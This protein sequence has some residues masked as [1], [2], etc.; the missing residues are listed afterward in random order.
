[1]SNSEPTEWLPAWIRRQLE[2]GAVPRATVPVADTEAVYLYG[3]IGVDVALASTGDV[4]VSEYE[5]DSVE[6]A[7]PSGTWRP[8][9]RLER[10]GYLVLGAR[11]FTELAALL[12]RN[13]SD[14][15]GCPACRST[16]DWHIF[17][18]DRKESLR[19]REMICKECGGLGWQAGA[20]AAPA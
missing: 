18:A 13:P 1:M 3:S 14:S 11:R 8:A 17:S 2:A 19:I 20:A 16:G 7:A 15:T 6:S 10:I 9:G 12:P 4:Y 5:L